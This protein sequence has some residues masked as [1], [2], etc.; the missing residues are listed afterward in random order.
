MGGSNKFLF[1][2]VIGIILLVIVTFSV[3]M[4]RPEPAYRDDSAP[5]GAAHNYLLALQQGDYERAYQ[6]IPADYKFPTDARDLE[7]DVHRNSWQFD[8]AD[9]FSLAIEA[10]K[11]RDD[12]EAVVTVRKTTFYNDGLLGSH[13]DF[14][15]F[16]MNMVLEGDLWKV[17]Q[18]RSYWSNCWGETREN[19]CR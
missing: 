11:L 3:V 9:D 18:A 4:L 16:T 14:S 17:S 15:T 5:D 13:Q 1:G 10:V 7:D 12:D 8:L 6:Y 19:W 2:I